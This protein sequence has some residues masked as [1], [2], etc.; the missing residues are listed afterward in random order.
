MSIR[1]QDW[2][3]R[4]ASS[5]FLRYFE[6]QLSV[7]LPSRGHSM[8]DLYT[9]EVLRLASNLTRLGKLQNPHTVVN[10]VSRLCGSKIEVGVRIENG[11]IKE[12]AQQVQACVLGQAAASILATHIVGASIQELAEATENLASMLSSGKPPPDG[13]F[14]EL[15]ALLHV[16]GYPR[17]H[18]ATLMP[19][20]AALEAAHKASELEQSF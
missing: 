20:R 5:K 4:L 10:K 13:R 9:L 11:Q 3:E 2:E 14:A 18:E 19:F 8:N 6:M 7:S 17:R 1:E 15:P 12:F 16:H